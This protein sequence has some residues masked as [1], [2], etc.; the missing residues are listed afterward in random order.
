MS[1]P[2][3][4][5]GRRP[6]RRTRWRELL[7]A[8]ALASLEA[9]AE[10]EAE[11]DAEAVDDAPDMRAAHGITP[12][13]D[14]RIIERA[15]Q[16]AAR[17]GLLAHL[18]ALSELA[19][20]PV[21]AC[22]AL[23]ALSSAGILGA[24][25]GEGRT[26]N[27]VL[28]F[29]SVLGLHALA[30]VLWLAALLQRGRGASGIG[31][32]ALGLTGRFAGREKAALIEAGEE[33]LRRAGLAP[34]AFG[35]FSHAVWSAAF[36]LVLAGL[37]IA[38]SFQ[39]F[40]LTWE[41]TILDAGVFVRFITQA[42]WLPSLLGF[43]V[44]DASTLAPALNEAGRHRLLAWWLIG[45]TFVYG[46]LPRLAL[47]GLCA[48]VL[49]RRARR[50]QLDP[51]APWVRRLA[52]R[53]EQMDRSAVIDVEHRAVSA[54]VA[55]P[56]ARS[57]RPAG[58]RRL[59]LI[60]FE[61]PPE[62]PWP[63]PGGPLPAHWVERIDGSAAQRRQALDAITAHDITRVLL[64]VN[65]SASPDRGTERFLRALQPE[66]R[67]LAL[68]PLAGADGRTDPARWRRWLDGA[69]LGAVSVHDSA[70]AARTWACG[71]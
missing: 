16:R 4:A 42:G 50:L 43:P 60:G 8:Q 49:L 62:A 69:G 6:V 65:G 57:E 58:P 63:P 52:T 9:G 64:L 70:A 24:V 34:W 53:F 67:W 66:R 36:V 3:A 19:W 2:A 15:W 29:G 27:V 22:V 44:A 18:Q 21:L 55:A 41:T 28:A 38:F 25:V 23:V 37:F 39:A 17:S 56:A 48:G 13:T 30:L 59:A 5:T 54:A 45:A 26:I 61:L 12:R 10:A 14:A 47:A 20:L 40:R 71:S 11:A 31:R 33:L 7:V 35:L 1:G 51:A 68:W 32:V 46:L